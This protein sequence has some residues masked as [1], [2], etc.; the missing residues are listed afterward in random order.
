MKVVAQFFKSDGTHE[1]K[2]TFFFEEAGS[3][4][5]SFT[6]GLYKGAGPAPR[7]AQVVVFQPEK[8]YYP[9]YTFLNNCPDVVD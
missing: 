3:K 2:E 6:W 4:T 5:M 1:L 7:W 9:T 8:V